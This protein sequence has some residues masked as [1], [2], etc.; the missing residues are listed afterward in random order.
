[1]VKR[2]LDLSVRLADHR[3]L[4]QGLFSPCSY[5]Q[6]PHSCPLWSSRGRRIRCGF[7]LWFSLFHFI[8]SIQGFI[9]CHIFATKDEQLASYISWKYTYYQ[10]N[11]YRSWRVQWHLLDWLV[12]SHKNTWDGYWEK[13]STKLT[14]AVYA[15]QLT[16]FAYHSCNALNAVH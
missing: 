3:G 14:C 5:F 4:S 8:I 2:S 1:M 11:K 10:K 13:Y 12:M 6:K 7:Q 15:S 9:D 16:P